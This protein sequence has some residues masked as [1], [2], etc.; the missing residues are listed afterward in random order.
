MTLCGLTDKKEARKQVNAALEVLFDVS[1]SYDDSKNKNKSRNYR[2]MRLVDD[3]GIKNGIVYL[4]IA[5]GFSEMLSD[6]P[7]MPYPLAILQASKGTQHRNAYYI[8]RKMAEH[9]NMNVGKRNENIISVKALLKASPYLATEDEV[10]NSD[11]H[12]DRRIITPFLTDLE[13]AC[14][15]LGISSEGYELH[16]AGGSEIPDDE[17]ASLD[18]QTFIDAY[19]RFDD[20]PDYPDQT[21]RLE[22][23]AA[24][25]QAST[26]TP[27]KKRKTNKKGGASTQA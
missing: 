1:I 2:D 12:F 19:V 7:V 13:E 23:K 25:Q 27:K 21:K 4:H 17:L 3:K 9:K 6:C 22:A 16:Y 20:L 14:N 15:S 26:G 8:A 24:K 18:Y 10:S 5:H 11:R